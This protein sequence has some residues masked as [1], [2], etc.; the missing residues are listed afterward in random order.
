MK[1]DYL[2]DVMGNVIN[3]LQREDMYKTYRQP[4]DEGKKS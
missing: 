1:R 3:E 4:L 2:F